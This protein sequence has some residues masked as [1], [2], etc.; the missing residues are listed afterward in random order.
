MYLILHL[1]RVHLH[2]TRQSFFGHYIGKPVDNTSHVD[3]VPTLFVYKPSMAEA[4][5][6]QWS[7]CQKQAMKRRELADEP[8]Q[9]QMTAAEALML[10]NEAETHSGVS[11]QAPVVVNSA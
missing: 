11:T 7:E 9:N 3:Y 8:T 2:I 4:V 6:R 5:S 1:Y 10:V